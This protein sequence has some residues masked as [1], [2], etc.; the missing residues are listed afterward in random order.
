M[1]KLRLLVLLVP[2][3]VQAQ[4]TAISGTVKD[5]S[6]E[7]LMGATIILKGAAVGAVAD[8]D[9][10]YELSN[11]P[12]GQ[13]TLIASFTGF[14]KQEKTIEVS[15]GGYKLD[16]VLVEDALQM[17]EVVITGSFDERTRMEASVSI[18]TLPE[19]L[20]ERQAPVSTADM[21]KNV[22]GVF[23]NSSLGEVRNIVYSRGV[24]ANSTDGVSGY[25][26]VS[27]QEDG[28]PVTNV[29]YAN[30]GPDYFL[31]NDITVR[32]LE[33]VRGGS[34]SVT[35]FNAPGGIFNYISKTGGQEFGGTVQAKFGILGDGNPYT[36]TDL[37][38]GGPTGIEN[39]Y[40]NIGGFYRRDDGPRNP[41]YP[42]NRGGQV[43]G[44]LNLVTE[45]TQIKLYAK[46]L[47]DINGSNSFLPAVNF[48]D[49]Q[50]AGG[51]SQTDNF[52][53]PDFSSEVPFR[54][55]GETFQF[56][57][58][59]LMQSQDFHIGLNLEQKLGRNWEVQNKFKYS[60]KNHDWNSGGGEAPQG[61]DQFG[62]P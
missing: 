29:T 44:N 36:R 12:L 27:L 26:Y 55:T 57:S 51:F 16:F 15:N 43:R 7:P 61:I 52:F 17:D 2:T 41:E 24:S 25:S 23:V 54:T 30:F 32:R 45:K 38:L 49:P 35:S 46:Y 10:R 19:T 11:V 9:G 58:R 50:V 21:L 14:A 1:T 13:I 22:P 60:I 31:R 62:S 20:L 33:A 37:N 3:W 42:F 18:T 40:F 6:G 39:L 47:N 56:T 28:L 53:F 4:S 48:D 59:D 8:F 34:A 5:S